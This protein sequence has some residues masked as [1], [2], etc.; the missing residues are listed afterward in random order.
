LEVRFWFLVSGC[1]RLPLA[2]CLLLL[3]AFCCFLPSAAFCC[4]PGTFRFSWVI[5]GVEDFHGKEKSH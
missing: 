1:C 4:L 2:F 5:F 3:S